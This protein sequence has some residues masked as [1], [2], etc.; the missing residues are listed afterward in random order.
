MWHL[1]AF[2]NKIFKEFLQGG[3]SVFLYSSESFLVHTGEK[4]KHL[5]ILL[6]R[7]VLTHAHT[8]IRSL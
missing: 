7:N 1:F 3:T 4:H 8:V 6:V 5:P 2:L